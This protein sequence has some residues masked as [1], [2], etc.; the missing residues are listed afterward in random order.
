V[1]FFDATA[2]NRKNMHTLARNALRKLR[3]IRHP[4]VLKFIDVVETESTIHIVTERVQ[5]LG[6]A[7][8]SW[9]SK[10]A[11]AREEWLVWGLHRIAVRF[12]SYLKSSPGANV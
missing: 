10:S 12:L 4:D 7:I 3:T 6:V 9:S 2:S 5:P 1:F 11:A 8:S